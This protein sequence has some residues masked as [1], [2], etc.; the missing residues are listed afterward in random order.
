MTIRVLA[1]SDEEEESDDE[2]AAAGAD[3]A[4]AADEGID[5]GERDLVST[6]PSDVDDVEDAE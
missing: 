2:A 1:D 4:G 5:Q 6:R 3:G